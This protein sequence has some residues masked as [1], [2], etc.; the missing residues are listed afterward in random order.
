MIKKHNN[1]IVRTKKKIIYEMIWGDDVPFSIK[2]PKK[3]K[4]PPFSETSPLY[5]SLIK[6]LRQGKQNARGRPCVHFLAMSRLF[7]GF[8]GF[9]KKGVFS[10]L[11]CFLKK[12]NLKINL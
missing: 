5:Q 6:I 1:E 12:I 4:K 10:V 8:S 2:M 3:V 9:Q 7:S 11:E